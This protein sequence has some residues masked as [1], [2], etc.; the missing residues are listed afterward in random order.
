ME[1][2]QLKTF[3]M[4]VTTGSFTQASLLLN[5]AQSNVTAQ[6]QALE[7]DLGVALFDR[8]GRNVVL[9]TAGKQLLSYSSR[10]LDLADEAQAVLA[11]KGE[12]LG[13]ITLGAP[14]TLCTYR[15]PAV[16][17]QFRQQNP[18]V[19]VSFRPMLDVDLYYGVRRGELELAFLLQE[20]LHAG[21]LVVENL[22]REP[23]VVIS[24]ADHPLAAQ[25]RVRPAD[26]EGETVLLTENGC[27]YRHLFEQAVT[28]EG[29]YTVIKQEFNS[30]ETI[31]QC[32]LAGLGIAFLPR[33]AVETEISQGRL[34]VLNWE[35]SF[36]V[37]TQLIY[38]Q[39]K[40]LSPA[41][42]GFMNLCRKLWV[43]NEDK[44]GNSAY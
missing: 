44:I 32:V 15:L 12:S 20:P 11:G 31:K 22:I 24:A 9:T 7:K 36:A 3:R 10:I 37:V 41:A 23:M 39:E 27:G 38:N 33:I 34:S 19:H 18:G 35:T 2:K 30:I 1:L 29:M 8:L 16:L 28:R 26:L 17:R 13:A 4:V 25:P 14:E 5:Y 40:W 43:S 42:T 6:I 21:G